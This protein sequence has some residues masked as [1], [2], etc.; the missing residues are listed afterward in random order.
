MAM[1]RAYT[2]TILRVDIAMAIHRV[3]AVMALY[4]V[5]TSCDGNLQG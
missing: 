4:R 2:T 3:D 1:Y 5:S